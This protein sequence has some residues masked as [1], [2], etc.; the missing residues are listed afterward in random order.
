MRKSPRYYVDLLSVLL[1]KELK[2]R[3]KSTVLGYAWSVLHPLAFAGA[4]FLVFRVYVRVRVEN[5]ALFLIA[6]L[7]PWQW[8]ANSITGTHQHFLRNGSLLKKVCFPRCWTPRAAG[9]RCWPA[10]RLA[11][12]TG[13]ACRPSPCGSSIF[14]TSF[15]AS[16][17][18]SGVLANRSMS[19]A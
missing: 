12:S 15:A 19:S 3:Y 2:V 10:S 8:F 13:S 11:G 17:A 1:A 14:A 5:C 4:F 6:G 9:A 7:F 16:A 18:C